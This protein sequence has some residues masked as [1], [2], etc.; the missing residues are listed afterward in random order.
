MRVERYF[1][2]IDLGGF[3]G[4]T[5]AHGDEEAVWVLGLFRWHVREVATRRGVRVAKWLG[6]GA[7]LVGVES[8]PLIE[9][10]IEVERR[11]DEG[12]S[13]LLLRAGLSGGRVIL[14][15]GDDYIGH[16]VNLAARMGQEAEPH[17]ILA[18]PE[19]GP[20]APPWVRVCPMEPI[21][22][23]GFREPV[24][25]VNLE[26]GD[27]DRGPLVTDPIC[28]MEIPADAV[29]ET[30]AGADGETVAFCSPSCAEMWD[31]TQAGDAPAGGRSWRR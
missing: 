11:V 9:T 17:E 5:E 12:E 22:L 18:I 29:V 6:D 19:L 3:T 21:R 27:D 24:E 4:F 16:P 31:G 23:R 15:E 30:R 14:M 13:P 8:T 26:W 25:V 28:S 2:F 7:M 20:A 10:V 1:A